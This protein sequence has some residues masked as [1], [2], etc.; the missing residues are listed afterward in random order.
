ARINFLSGHFRRRR[1]G[2]INRTEAAVRARAR[3]MG[4]CLFPPPLIGCAGF[5]LRTASS[6]PEDERRRARRRTSDTEPSNYGRSPSAAAGGLRLLGR[7]GHKEI[8]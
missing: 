4:Y 3:A 6:V 2:K 1:W 5:S 8:Q 7:M